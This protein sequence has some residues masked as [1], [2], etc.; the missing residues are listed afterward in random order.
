MLLFFPL[1]SGNHVTGWDALSNPSSGI[2][3]LMTCVVSCSNNCAKRWYY[4]KKIRKKDVCFVLFFRYCIFIIIFLKA[5]FPIR[6]CMNVKVRFK[7]LR[8][9]Q[10]YRV[11]INHNNFLPR[12]PPFKIGLPLPLK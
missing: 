10:H 11:C 3:M 7:V 12:P 4:K 6:L 1:N 5:L 9:I 8:E 2:D